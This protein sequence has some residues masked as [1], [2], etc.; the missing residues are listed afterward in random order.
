M[1][2]IVVM[3]P[4]PTCFSDGYW[5]EA[6]VERRRIVLAFQ[7]THTNVYHGNNDQHAR[8]VQHADNDQHAG[9]HRAISG[10]KRTRHGATP[11]SQTV[12]TH[13]SVI[14]III[15]AKTAT[16][17]TTTAP[18]QVTNNN[19]PTQVT[20]NNSPTQV[21]NTRYSSKYCVNYYSISPWKHQKK[22]MEII[23][24]SPLMKTFSGGS[25]WPS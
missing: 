24:I 5:L 14:V 15:A 10:H 3:L 11:T 4:D 13:V 7:A 2:I 16:D 6:P 23:I 8:N 17:V 21:T 20:N 9:E 18:T 22:T 12:V 25:S 1:V 19:S